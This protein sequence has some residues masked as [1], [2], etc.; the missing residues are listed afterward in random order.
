MH[1]QSY[2]MQH[3]ATQL[4]QSIQRP[5]GSQR[6][7]GYEPTLDDMWTG[8]SASRLLM[9]FTTSLKDSL[10]ALACTAARTAQQTLILVCCCMPC[11]LRPCCQAAGP[12]AACKRAIC[13]LHATAVQA[14]RQAEGY[15]GI[16]LLSAC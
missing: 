11:C 7:Q 4:Q 6:Q 2:C 1:I 10:D 14:A 16:P 15:Q 13:Q 5:S 12:T 3:C 8:E 9:R